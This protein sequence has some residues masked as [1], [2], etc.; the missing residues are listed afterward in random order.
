MTDKLTLIQALQQDFR[1]RRRKE[2]LCGHDVWVSP[3]TVDENTLLGQRE[4]EG[5]PG[6]LAEMLLMKCTDEAGK[7][8]FSRDDKDIL[9]KQ[10]AGDRVS[11]L[12][13]AI[14]G[15]GVGEQTKN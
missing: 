15:P 4:P 11:H 7:P 13:S 9:I 2:T 14:V 10:V 3:M 5:G 6:R 12:I 8:V 1:D